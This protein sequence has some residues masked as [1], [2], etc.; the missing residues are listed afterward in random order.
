MYLHSYSNS[1]RKLGGISIYANTT[2]LVDGPNSPLRPSRLLPLWS[3]SRKSGA[4]AVA[5]V[6]TSNLLG[7]RTSLVSNAISSYLVRSKISSYVTNQRDFSNDRAPNLEPYGRD[8]HSYGRLPMAVLG[9]NKLGRFFLALLGGL[10]SSTVA[11][12]VYGMARLVL[13]S[14]S[15]GE[16]TTLQDL[17]RVMGNEN[18]TPVTPQDI[19]SR[20]LHTEGKEAGR[21]DRGLSFHIAIDETV[22]TYETMVKK[23]LNF[24]PKYHAA[25]DSAAENVARQNIQ[26][27]RNLSR[28]GSGN[29]DEG[30]PDARCNLR[31]YFTK[32]ASAELHN[33]WFAAPRYSADIA[34]LGSISKNDAK[35][36]QRWAREKWDLPILT[37]FIGATPT[38]E[39]LPL[40]AG[41]MRKVDKLG[42]WS[43]YLRLLSEWKHRP[44]FGPRQIA[45][46][47]FRFYGSHALDRHKSCTTTPSVHLSPYDPDDNTFDLRPFLSNVEQL[48]EK[49]AEKK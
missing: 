32:Y 40:S 2:G 6:E 23:K 9:E 14:I 47:V 21:D 8:P 29:V 17:R 3:I 5:S 44:G 20:L 46:K 37:E 35:D 30:S 33:R 45:E 25:G 42:P 49:L 36:F 15:R 24:T 48:E 39:L 41:I 27:P 34:P 7:S 12:F 13:P 31:G 26:A 1:T 18:F 4:T 22:T 38:A 43:A 10:D 19:V 28:A 16:E 11:L